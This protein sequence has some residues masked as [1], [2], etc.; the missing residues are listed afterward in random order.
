MYLVAGVSFHVFVCIVWS[1][2][3]FGASAKVH[4]ITYTSLCIVRKTK[5]INYCLIIEKYTKGVIRLRVTTRVADNACTIRRND[6]IKGPNDGLHRSDLTL[7]DPTYHTHPCVALII[8]RRA[9]RMTG[10]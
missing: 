5:N 4:M 10:C 1:S 3:T 2:W 6:N 7:H 9:T 8:T